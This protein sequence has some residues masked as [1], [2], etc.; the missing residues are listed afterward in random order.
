MS[1]RIEQPEKPTPAPVAP[2]DPQAAANAEATAKA[3]AERK[4]REEG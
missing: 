2:A 4:A 1:K 3:I